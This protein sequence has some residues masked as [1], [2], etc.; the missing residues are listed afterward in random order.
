M[1]F[2]DQL[3]RIRSGQFARV[4]ILLGNLEDDGSVFSFNE[5]DL[6]AFIA[7][8]FGLST[9]FIA[10]TLVRALYPGLADPQVIAAAVRDMVFRW[11]VHL[12]GII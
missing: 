1:I 4:P 12:F 6:S 7:G 10:P 5:S 2:D 8:Q 11:C 9:G 3:Q